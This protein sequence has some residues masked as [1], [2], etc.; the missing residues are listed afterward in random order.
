MLLSNSRITKNKEIRFYEQDILLDNH[1]YTNDIEVTLDVDYVNSGIG[2]VIVSDGGLA[3]KDNGESYLFRVGHNNYSIV[4]RF[5]DKVDTLETGVAI[6]IKPY[7]KNLKVRL[8]KVN[9]R[10]YFYV[11]DKLLTSKYISVNLESY[12]VGYYSN[13]GNSINSINIASEVPENWI[14]NMKNTNGGYINFVNDGFYIYDCDNKAEIEQVNIKL[15]KNT[16]SN[17][18]YYL[19]YAVEELSINDI[20][21]YVFLSDDIRYSDEE[22][23]ILDK[24]NKFQL[25]SDS[26]VNL[27][28]AGTNGGITSIHITES[29]NDFYVGTQYD[30][31]ELKPSLMKVQTQELSKITWKGIIYST[32][33]INEQQYSIVK[34]EN[35][36]YT[37]NDCNI[38]LNE[39]YD[40]SLDLNTNKLTI[41]MKNSFVV[42]QLSIRD[43]ITIFENINAII[44]ELLLYKKSG[45][46]VNPL[47]QETDKEYVPAVVQSPII[48]TTT[49]D[50]PLELSASYRI[51][52]EN[53]EIYY[54]FTNYEREIFEPVNRIKL[55]KLASLKDET[56][57]VYG[58]LKESNVYEDK[59]L[60]SKSDNIKAI[61]QY[62]DLYDVF[63]ENDLYS[64][65]KETGSII[66]STG[67]DIELKDKYKC[68]IVDYL[69]RDSYA[70]NYK[71]K[72]DSYEVDISCSNNTKIYYDAMQSDN[73][74][75]VNASNY[76]IINTTYNNNNYIV[77]KGR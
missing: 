23:N 16:D 25:K 42:L 12:M 45:I 38:D 67:S 31:I 1:T 21:P 59:I 74:D 51:I 11:N 55:S 77:L 4:R 50:T 57:I 61:D 53:G 17:K 2:I 18:Y 27:K 73:E 49:N 10:F 70:I 28:F 62:C 35:K 41:T 64:I 56:V 36:R 13:A 63:N 29:E 43:N 32:P 20:K 68:F 47:V 33:N 24:D 30:S 9:N 60:Y 6:N 8:R 58:V 14:I 52:E 5:G 34:D 3:L 22:K 76:K 7:M 40:F 44:T 72:L 75:F 39:M 48:V 66:I 26:L 15:K 46:V 69:K 65:N 71:Y 19:K 37:L 54:Y